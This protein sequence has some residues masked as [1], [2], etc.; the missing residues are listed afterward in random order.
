[1]S[2]RLPIPGGDDGDWG[3]ILN[4]FLEVSH[5]ADGTL[6]P[7]ALTAAGAGTYSKPGSGIPA[8]DLD[9]STQTIISS[10]ASKY[11]KPPGGVPK[12]DLASSVQT[13]LTT[14][15]SS[16]Q[17]VNSKTPVSGNVVINVAD[18]NDVQGGSGATNNQVLS[19]D[20]GTSKWVPATVSSTTVSDATTSSKG[21]VELAG[22]LGGTAIAP[23]VPKA[24]G[25]RSA[26]TA[27]DVSAATAPTAGQVLTATSSTAADWTTPAAGVTLDATAS[28]IQPDTTTGT[29][30]AGATGK[31][32]DAGHQH[33][34]VAHDHTTANKGG[35]INP[36]TALTATG[37]PSGSTFLRGDNTWST[38][39]AGVTLDSTSTDIAPLGTQAAGAIGKAADAGHVHA[40][41]TLDQVNPPAA[42][43]SLNSHKIT[44]L[45]NG[46]AATDAAAFG[47]IP[48]TASSI[49]GL[50]A[51]NN[52][53]DVNN[54]G[55][56]R[57]NI[58]VP[59]LSPAACVAAANVASLSGLNTYDG[60]T[61]TA[62]DQVLLI[63]QSTASQN[64][65][66]VAAAGAWTRP[67]DF[68]TG[69]S[70][71]ARSIQIIQGTT[72]GGSTYLLQTNSSITVDTT[73][74]TWVSQLPSS[75]VTTS[76]RQAIQP[77]TNTSSGTYTNAEI[78]W[79]MSI[80]LAQTS[81][82]W[83]LRV[84]N[85]NCL[86][87]VDLNA[88]ASFTGMYIGPQAFS[89]SGLDTGGFVSAPSQALSS[90]TLPS[91]SEYV[92]AW[93]TSPSLQFTAGI[94]YLL[95]WAYTGGTTQAA[96]LFN[97]MWFVA[98]AGTSSHIADTSGAAYA[99]LA[100]GIFDVRIEYQFTANKLVGLA[101]GDSTTGTAGQPTSVTNAGNSYHRWPERWSMRTGNTLCNGGLGSANMSVTFASSSNWS[102]QR[103]NPYNASSNPTGIQY[104]FAIVDLSINDVGSGLSTMQTNFTNVVSQLK[105]GLGISR[106]FSN[107]VK[108]HNGAYTRSRLAAPVAAG[109]TSISAY[110]SIASGTSIQIG[111]GT[112]NSEV[113]TTS[114]SPTGSPPGPYTLPVP[115]LTYAH[116]VGEAI[117]GLNEYTRWA[118]N[119]YLR[120][121]P[122]GIEDCFSTERA[123][124]A[125]YDRT[126]WMPSLT[127]NEVAIIHPSIQGHAV[128]A[129]AVPNIQ[130]ITS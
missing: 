51:A 34:L 1:M 42:D 37:T 117:G 17:S 27:I 73:S 71:K 7:S 77:L 109:A 103:M 124:Q 70:V 99:A 84:R 82:Q 56:S 61:L 9:T 46:S 59:S 20:S 33:P 122:A 93:V 2:Q 108:P 47:Q 89:S 67:T 43:V 118:F 21:I 36:T 97:K 55:T 48:T 74:Q 104:D 85:I 88:G 112:L 79:R 25:L 125:P 86:T 115:A 35:Q 54:A 28:D 119:D 60:Y 23:T 94:P 4:A 113:V 15:D 114:G 31:A 100:S 98:G 50:L 65:P 44:S 69:N 106:I 58:H 39:A 127:T 102:Y 62:G 6:I 8:S 90:F 16:V 66:W 68:A 110:D 13:S 95:S 87:G 53:S 3:Y 130:P 116:L 29:A 76:Q 52:L 75:V 101:I 64:G 41:P 49:G 12:T 78:A 63:A 120:A 10:V 81:T 91:G 121:L 11:V 18:I 26:T 19:Y 92:S 83:R 22:D 40:M 107:T 5:N 80:N 129:S 96:S 32:A 45:S 14:A 38:P 126:I 123:I 72:Y 128:I 24:S 111:E 105:T 57:Q 30:V